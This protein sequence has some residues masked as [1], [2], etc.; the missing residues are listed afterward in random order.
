MSAIVEYFSIDKVLQ[1]MALRTRQGKERATTL[2]TFSPNQSRLDRMRDY[3]ALLSARNAHTKVNG[4]D[5]ASIK[6]PTTVAGMPT[7]HEQPKKKTA[8]SMS[9]NV[10]C[11]PCNRDNMFHDAAGYCIEC[12]EY[13][14]ETCIKHH[15][16]LKITKNHT[17]QDRRQMPKVKNQI[18]DE[19]TIEICTDH[20]EELV[21]YFCMDHDIPTCGVC[22]TLDHRVCRDVVYIPDIKCKETNKKCVTTIKLLNNLAYQFEKAQTDTQ[23][24]LQILD[25]M[26][27]DY[28]QSLLKLHQDIVDLLRKL[29]RDSVK[30]MDT[31]RECELGYLAAR[32]ETCQEAGNTLRLSAT[33]LDNAK[34][35]GIDNKVFL[36]MRKTSKQIKFYE[37]LLADIYRK[38]T[39]ALQFKFKCDPKVRDFLK[40]TANIGQLAVLQRPIRTVTLFTQ[41]K[42]N[43]RTDNLEV[44][45]IT[46]SCVMEDGRIVIADMNNESL[47]LFSN[48]QLVT[49]S[50]LSSEPW[51]LCSVFQDQV[52]VSLPHEKKL[53]FLTIG[54]TIH[55]LKKIGHVAS[56]K[57]ST[58]YGVAFC[59]DCLYVTC[60]K[61]EPPCVKI[62]DMQGSELQ[63]IT[64][65]SDEVSL[66]SDPRYITVSND[67]KKI[68][69][70][71]CGH[72]CIVTLEPTKDGAE[73]T[74]YEVP[75]VNPP[76]GLSIQPEGDLYV[77]GF[78][79]NTILRLSKEGEFQEDFIASDG[80][81]LQPQSIS[82]SATDRQL[83]VTMQKS[84]LV[85]VFQ[86][87]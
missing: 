68:Y 41:F 39:N 58:Y 19:E 44:C 34:R 57:T 49:Q 15:R 23:T 32:H 54:S 73:N 69:V 6:S 46:S 50:K 87:T 4:A 56:L 1:K 28:K 13:F 37:S 10:H 76:G 75:D 31:L 22:A 33:Q 18:P 42:V 80:G 26:Q 63:Q 12:S 7:I 47:K 86:L 79:T 65:M 59:Q 16:N 35:N 60:P 61:D 17:L 24:N 11:S 25:K 40:H 71:D 84:N 52:I 38:N 70:S 72:N 48:N 85:K 8:K 55:P 3:S 21:R 67:C 29:E 64:A 30:N 77:C 5:T 2:P 51:D 78:K 9:T 74:V 36:Y 82:Y 81:L 53:Q 45:D 43:S 20:P 62:L 66:L 14:C 27:T 83:I